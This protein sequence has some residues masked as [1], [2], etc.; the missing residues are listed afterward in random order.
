M[1][2]NF[3]VIIYSDGACKDNPGIGGYGY[4]IDILGKKNEGMGAELVTTN[5]RMELM[6]P[7]VALE[8]LVQPSRIK[9]VTDSQYVTKGM[10]EWIEGWIAKGWRNAAKKPVKNQD[11][12]LRLL[13]QSKIHQI[14]WVWVK[15]HAGHVENERCDFLANEAIMRYRVQK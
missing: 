11:L 6:G 4:I 1:D 15:G 14:S 3:D 10:S 12:W 13:K 2:D 7:I 5:N 9:A 8:S